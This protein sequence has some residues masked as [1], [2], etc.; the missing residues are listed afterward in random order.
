MTGRSSRDRATTIGFTLLS[1]AVAFWQKPGW[2]Y[3]DTK[4]DLHVDPSR[5]LAFVASVWT[6]TT[7]L[8]EVHSA[9]YSGY[10]WPMGPF[11]SVLHSIGLGPWVVQ[12]LWLALLLSL[13]AWGLLRLLDVLIGRPRSCVH[14]VAA[15]F[16]VLNPYT[17]VFVARTTITLLGY[18]ALPWLLLVTYYGVRAT[19]GLWRSWRGWWWAAAFALILTSTG[20][21]VNAAVV[22]WMLVGPLVLA[23]YEPT[24]GNVPWRSSFGFLGRVGILGLLASAWWIVPVLVHVRYGIDFLQFTEQP[25]SIWATNSTTES[26]RLMGFW[27]S[28][29]GVGYGAT[30][31]LFSDVSTMLF[32]PLV[33]GASLLL[34]A[35]A[36]A[37]FIRARRLVYAPLFLALVVVGTTIMVA[38]FPDGTPLRTGMTWVYH[39]VFVLRFMRTTYKAGPLVALGLACLLGLAAGQLL[40]R[41]RSLPRPRIRRVAPI[42][43]GVALAALIGFAALPLV[44]GKAIDTQSAWKRIPPAWTQAGRD[45]DRSLAPNTRALVLPGQIFAYYNWG[46]TIDAILP[47]LTDRLVAVRYQTP[48][49][50]LHAVDLLMTVDDLVQQRRL[51]PG[52]LPALLRLMGVGAVVSGTDDDTSRS[53]ALDPAAAAGV[54]SEQLGPTPT[55]SYGAPRSLTSSVVISPRRCRC[56]RFAATT[57]RARAGSCT[58]TRLGR[59]RCSTAAPRASLTLRRSAGCRPKRR[60]CTRATYRRPRF[61][62]RRQPAPRS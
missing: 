42:A 59:R 41:L 44:Q 37:G 57:S 54:L 46:A 58:S 2:A 15:A 61:G 45:L 12:R 25:S 56:P 21:G 7:D 43:A 17:V 53:G 20:G 30:R 24:I 19:P 14:I 48:Y 13:S 35:F 4:I 36:V 40:S 38:G 1:L 10:L 60:C 55:R 33:V 39:H 11:Y 32:N 28:Y 5:F 8:G 18:A 26:L 6:P 22:G 51:V 47:R 49:S 27:T 52:E 34:P 9:Q 29:I 16:Y 62:A 31:P 50:D 3:T 23:L